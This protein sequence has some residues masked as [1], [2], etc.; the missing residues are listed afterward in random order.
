MF[1]FLKSD[2]KQEIRNKIK[3]L[4]FREC[5]WSCAAEDEL[6]HKGKTAI[7]EYADL[8]VLGFK[9]QQDRLKDELN[10]IIKEEKT[11]AT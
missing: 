8:K 1:H 10:K 3:S 2:K 9:L 6:K 7:W 4:S 5:I 11:Y